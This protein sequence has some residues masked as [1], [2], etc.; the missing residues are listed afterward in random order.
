MLDNCAQGRKA[1]LKDTKLE[2]LKRERGAPV[3]SAIQWVSYT[4]AE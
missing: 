3:F 1:N 2:E 4:R